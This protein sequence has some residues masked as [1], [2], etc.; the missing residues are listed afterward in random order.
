MLKYWNFSDLYNAEH[1]SNSFFFFFSVC[2]FYEVAVLETSLCLTSVCF[3][4]DSFPCS[5]LLFSSIWKLSICPLHFLSLAMPSSFKVA[6]HNL[7][8]KLLSI[9][10]TFPT[11]KFLWAWFICD[12]LTVSTADSG[13]L[14]F[15]LYFFGLR[16]MSGIVISLIQIF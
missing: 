11:F 12:I 4:A 7:S 16:R 5:L 6:L 13:T 10:S 3:S 2:W 1:T 8:A 15:F 9:L 14:T